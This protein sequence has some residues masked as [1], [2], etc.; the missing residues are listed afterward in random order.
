MNVGGLIL[1]KTL[2]I[3]LN[4]LQKKLDKPMACMLL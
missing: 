3:G 4:I 1:N 2:Y